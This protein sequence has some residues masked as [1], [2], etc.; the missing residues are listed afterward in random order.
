MRATLITLAATQASRHHGGSMASKRKQAARPERAAKARKAGTAPNARRTSKARKA[1][2]PATID[3]YLARVSAQ[4]RAALA[5][6]RATIRKAV[7]RAEEC[8]SY[9]VPAF[10]IGSS[11]LVGFGASAKHCSFFPMSGRTIGEHAH[12]LASYETSK[13][14]IRF[15][16]EEPLPDRLLRRLIEARLAEIASKRA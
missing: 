2:P 9:G 14:A 7:P 16:P 1:G 6:L 10:R 3:D 5:R 8:I 4:Q 12:L 11:V 15:T 13:G